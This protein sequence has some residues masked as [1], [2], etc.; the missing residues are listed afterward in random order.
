MDARYFQSPSA[1]KKHMHFKYILQ[2]VIQCRLLY[3]LYNTEQV[4]FICMQILYMQNYSSQK[5]GSFF[6]K[7]RG[8]NQ[9]FLQSQRKVNA[10]YLLCLFKLL[11]KLFKSSPE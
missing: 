6:K 7:N 11:W 1:I 5:E 4:L 9:N 8:K 2:Y 10:F 3:D